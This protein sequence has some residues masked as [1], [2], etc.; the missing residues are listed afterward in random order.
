MSKKTNAKPKSVRGSRHKPRPRGHN[1]LKTNYSGL[2]SERGD[3][4]DKS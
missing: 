4:G 3:F 1:G 2:K